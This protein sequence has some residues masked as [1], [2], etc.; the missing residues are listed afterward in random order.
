MYYVANM[1]QFVLAFEANADAGYA[2]HYRSTHVAAST[3][4]TYGLHLYSFA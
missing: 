4:E 1:D 3:T 2:T